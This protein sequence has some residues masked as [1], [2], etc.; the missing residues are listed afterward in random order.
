MNIINKLTLRHLFLNKKR[1]LVTVVGVII[2]VAMITAVATIGFSFLDLMQRETINQTGYWHEVFLNSEASNLKYIEEDKNTDTVTINKELGYAKLEG[3]QNEYK[4]FLF[5]TSY[6][7]EGIENIKNIKLYQGRFPENENEVLISKHISENGGVNYKIG[8][9]I[10]LSVGNRYSIQADGTYSTTALTQNN[11]Y[12][13]DEEVFIAQ[14]DITYTIV[15]F[16]ERPGF[17]PSW[18]AGYTIITCLDKDNLRPSERVN[19]YVALNNVTRSLYDGAIELSKKF[20]DSS[21]PPQFKIDFNSTLLQYYGI[22]SN[23]AIT[24]VMYTFMSILLLIIITGAVSLIY[25]AF[26]IS[27]SERSR[28]LGMLSSVGAT[29]KQKRNSV[30]FEGFLIGIISIPIGILSGT[31]GIGITFLFVDPLIKSIVTVDMTESLKLVV[32]PVSIGLSVLFSI[33]TIFIS[34]FIP[35]KKASGISPLDAI[36]QAQDI[37]IKGKSVK[38][39]KFINKIFGF[40][41]NLGL[42]NLKRNKHR[43]RS[44]I[45]SLVISVVL[46][47]TV[48]SFTL[49]AQKSMDLIKIEINFDLAVPVDKTDHEVIDKITALDNIDVYTLFS[50]KNTETFLN[51]EK[52]TDIMKDN[53]FNESNMV[54]DEYRLY[55]NMISLNDE[56][57]KKYAAEVGADYNE[58]TDSSSI[59]GIFINNINI[60]IGDGFGNHNIL[61]INKGDSIGLSYSGEDSKKT[62]IGDITAAELTSLVPMGVSTYN[63][64]LQL[65]IVV[66]E[67]T[68]NKIEQ[69]YPEEMRYINS[70]LL[71]N[72][73]KPMELEKEIIEILKDRGLNY[74]FITNIAA[75]RN[76]EKNTGIVISIFV[77]GFIVLMAAICV[78]NIYNTI[79]TGISLRTREFAMLKSVGMTPKSFNKILNYESFFYG[80]KA[81]L[82]G[83][84]ISFIVMLLLY[85][86]LVFGFEFPFTIPYWSVVGAI[87][88]VFIIIGLTMFFSSIKIKKE[89]IVDAL[90]QENI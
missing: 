35:A 23:D 26:S 56:A 55:I 66:S 86:S 49:Y 81:L 36:R 40:E 12:N 45:F 6:D 3:S 32:S 22:T 84:P 37:Q 13:T 41:G 1:T 54:G 48:A 68:L 82:Y 27:L 62:S 19:F 39:F 58:L 83:L 18:G 87:I 47:L 59:K 64:S 38:T 53:F 78:A 51:N 67:D 11:P 33:I 57:L 70:T 80:V 29:K 15:G 73:K 79:S 42:K 25:N 34:T 10:A 85:Y 8:D 24:R 77:I 72:S 20:T 16:I 52:F 5:I 60:R 76:I 63:R 43:S 30:F 75:N 65:A 14:N 74:S 28:Y 7:V 71:I 50:E 21:T 61:N 31:V 69:L 2:S 88:A 90:K 17:E 89:N 9:K 44:T 46:F 4:P